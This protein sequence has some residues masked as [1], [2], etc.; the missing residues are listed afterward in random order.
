MVLKMATKT[1]PRVSSKLGM[2]QTDI[3][4]SRFFTTL[5]SFCGMELE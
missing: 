5:Y 2:Y 4:G 3:R 1:S